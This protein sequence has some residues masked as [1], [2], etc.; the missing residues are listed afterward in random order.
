LFEEA[1]QRAENNPIFL[2][3]DKRLKL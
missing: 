2:E 3:L 1:G